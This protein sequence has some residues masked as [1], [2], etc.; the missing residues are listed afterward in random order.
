MVDQEV[1]GR[2]ALGVPLAFDG[3]IGVAVGIAGDLDDE[4]GVR[5]EGRA[6]TLRGRDR[7]DGDIPARTSPRV[8]G[9]DFVT[10]IVTRPA[11]RSEP[12]SPTP[13]RL[14]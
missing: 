12:L 4:E 9:A 14:L 7:D 13:Q 3:A 10:C 5:G 8:R 11:P 1:E 6:G 2:A